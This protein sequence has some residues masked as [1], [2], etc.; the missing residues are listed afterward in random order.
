MS[1][2]HK[3]K[4]RKEQNMS[5]MTE[6][7]KQA[8][9][10]AKKMKAYTLTFV[11]VMVL[12]LA[13]M[14]GTL[15]RTPISGLISRNTHALT[16]GASELSTT[17]LS[18]YYVD[19]IYSHYNQYAD[20]GDY[21]SMYAMWMEGIDF[22][23]PVGDQVKDEESGETWAE[24]YI[25][26]AIK[27]AKQTIALYEKAIS[28]GY[29]LSEDDQ[30]YLDSLE[31]YLKSAAASSGYSS[32]NGYLR[33]RYCD[34]ANIKTFKEYTKTS[35]IASGYYA[36]HMDSLE[37][38]VEDYREYDK[39]KY[40]EYSAYSYD[41]YR[42]NVSS[43]LKGGTVTKGEDGKETT[44]Y[45]DEENK[46]A[47]EAAKKD[48]Q[49]LAIADN[50]TLEKLNAAIKA[51]EVNK[52][53]KDAA[54]TTSTNVMYGDLSNEDIQK[55][56]SD[57]SRKQGDITYIEITNTTE[58]ENGEEVKTVSSYYV[59][60]FEKRNDNLMKLQNVRHILVAFEGGRKD[61]E[62][63]ET[64]YSETEKAA[65]KSAAQKLLDQWIAST[66]DMSQKDAEEAFAKLANKES[67]DG[68]GT[69]GGLYEDI[70]PGQMVSGFENWCFDETRKTGDTGLVETEY[71]YHVM[72]YVSEDEMTY[73]DYMVDADMTSDAME[74]W[75]DDLT[76]AIS[77]TEVNLNGIDRDFILI[78]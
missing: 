23:A 24:Y 6:K 56:L 68:D 42:V 28:D 34:G 22:S 53:V 11:V 40:N 64:V 72:Y 36:E 9:A 26:E 15:V 58:G 35:L 49:S 37:Y 4:L 16:V 39:D 52:D 7:Q 66:K 50:N 77:S 59:I 41:L 21:A 76:N 65:A 60:R 38:T 19:T 5:A 8:N 73:R 10:E 51:L 43:Y 12:V 20:Y 31:A 62:T 47:L 29:T 75:T 33:N 55:W 3:K 69:T 25:K 30:T 1:A 27:S 48:A 14:V 74:K 78:Y 54:A 45:S 18:Y 63:G 61:S 70:Y 46:A 2:S 67:D 57:P 17:D 32:V 71:G 44:T 13:I